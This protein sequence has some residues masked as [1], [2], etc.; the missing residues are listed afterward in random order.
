MNQGYNCTIGEYISDDII[1]V[2][3]KQYSTVR[4][5]E[6]SMIEPKYN[7]KATLISTAE[8][9][10]IYFIKYGQDGHFEK[11]ITKLYKNVSCHSMRRFYNYSDSSMTIEIAKPLEWSKFKN[12]FN[13]YAEMK[14]RNG[15]G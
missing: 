15:M 13:V 3:N 11:T 6:M 2:I 5:F 12:I 14:R 9:Y 7:R 10:D 1:R 4:R 8:G